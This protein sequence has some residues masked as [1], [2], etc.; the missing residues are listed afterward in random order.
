MVTAALSYCKQEVAPSFN[1]N[2]NY[3]SICKS[4][5]FFWETGVHTRTHTH[6]HV[7]SK[8]TICIQIIVHCTITYKDYIVV[9]HFMKTCS[10]NFSEILSHKEYVAFCRDC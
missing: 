4:N 1:Y 9:V 3:Y 10:T 2:N 7:F 5:T 8:L 6:T